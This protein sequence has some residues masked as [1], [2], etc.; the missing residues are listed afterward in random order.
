MAIS[1]TKKAE[2]PAPEVKEKAK[3]EVATK[4]AQI[5]PDIIGSKSDKVVFLGVIVDPTQKDKKTLGSKEKGTYQE[6]EG[7]VVVGYKIGLLE[8]HDKVPA[9]GLDPNS[10]D[11]ATSVGKPGNFVKGKKGDV[12]YLTLVETGA[13][14]LQPEF[15][16]VVTGH[17]S[18]GEGINVS[19]SV[20]KRNNAGATDGANALP[21]VS[22]RSTDRGV[23]AY[24]NPDNAFEAQ[25]E[26]SK[27]ESGK[28]TIRYRRTPIKEGP[29][30]KFAPLARN[31]QR[32]GGGAKPQ[33]GKVLNENSASFLAAVGLKL[34]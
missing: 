34:G 18:N 17:G 14:L 21:R 1:T 24:I 29:L 11:F 27:T 4:Q 8:D 12:L 5:N 10:T 28:E 32:S 15:N 31:T 26:R 6:S 20:R 7:H 3:A 16:G 19:V 2:A 22:L 25:Q 13:L 30:A 33:A 9:F 23:S